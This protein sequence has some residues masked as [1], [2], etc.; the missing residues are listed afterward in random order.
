[1][2]RNMPIS[3]QGDPMH[4]FNKVTICLLTFSLL[5]DTALSQ[6]RDR[7]KIPD[8]Y[9]WNLTD[10]YASDDAWKAA[11]EKLMAKLP[12]VEQFR[13]KLSDAS[14]LATCMETVSELSKE[15]A[16]LYVYAG[17]NSDLDLNNAKYL[18]MVQDMGKMG[19]DFAALTSYIEP[20]ILKMERQTIDRSIQQEPR[21]KVYSHYLDDILRRKSH[22]GTEGEEKI[23]A[24]A[25]LMADGPDNIY[26][27]FSNAEF[28]FPS[29]T[30]ADGK[31]V[32]LDKAAFNLYRTVPNRD[33]RA[34]VFAAYFDKLNEFRRTFG[35]QLYAQVKK[36]LF[37]MNARRYGSSLETALD[38]N[39]IPVAVYHSL[40]NGV[41]ANLATFHRYLNL[42]KRMLG[43]DQLH[44]YDM[45]APV[46]KNVDLAY[47][48]EEAQKH[49]LASLAPLGQDYVKTATKGFAERWVDVYPNTG[50]R[51]GA[52]SQGSAYDV[53]PYML[54]NY[55]GK[56]DDMST[57]THEFGHTMHSYLSN[58]NQPY[59]T[60]Q[61]S[62]FVAEVASTFNEALLIE[63][64]LKTTKDDGVR[65]SMLGSYLDNIK[66]T[67]FRQ[68][69]FAEFELR[70]HELA[71]K[72][73][74]LT[75]DELDKLYLDITRKYYGHDKGA[76]I[77]DE[78]VKAEWANVPHFYYNFYVFQYA[79]SFTAS[80]AL[81]EEVLAGDKTATE[82]YLT[83][84]KSGGS[85][86]PISLLKKAGVDMTTSQ[87]LELT[88][89]KMNR[90][91]DEMEKILDK[92]K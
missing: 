30:L 60:S 43:V 84:L 33:D 22:T 7:S 48:Y 27:V 5:S 3:Q 91:M 89:K 54:L 18:G 49:V 68:T 24:D 76:C 52:Y 77:V 71:E 21:L 35:T 6:E 8:K 16:R 29:V 13:G 85:D 67:V 73:Q 9:K 39:N 46:V 86:Y 51:A 50:K 19:S 47:T 82:R 40:V 64:M 23:I 31:T 90:V 4:P 81:S 57:L 78:N 1:M 53:H 45:Y 59:P 15:F 20:E 74:S 28:P 25:S 2:Y 44:Y 42:R 63:H 37:Y 12:T 32:K 65:L 69:Q 26:G 58:K 10:I 79:T 75:G 62:I 61:Y 88:M 92:K 70:I 80:S 17:M 38:V 87:P 72:G 36:D 34:K 55:N 41:N 14:S 66:G 56:Y 11:K 83:L